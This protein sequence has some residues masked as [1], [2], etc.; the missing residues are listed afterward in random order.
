M[1]VT[2]SYVLVFLGLSLVTKSQLWFRL[3]SNNRILNRLSLW[4]FATLGNHLYLLVFLCRICIVKHLID[5]RLA[6][7]AAISSWWLLERILL[8]F[9]NLLRFHETAHLGLLW[10][11]LGTLS[12]NGILRRKIY[13][14]YLIRAFELYMF[15]IKKR[16][17]NTFVEVFIIAERR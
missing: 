15:L 2:A 10:L 9:N 5:I 1:E 14:V 8:Q 17:V 16:F 6:L 4:R 3:L 7:F 13:R 11:W 12:K